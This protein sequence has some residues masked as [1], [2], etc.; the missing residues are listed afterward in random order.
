[1]TIEQT[2]EIPASHRLTLDLP[3]EIPVGRVIL[4]FTP[5]PP[6]PSAGSRIGFLRGQ[7]SVPPDF[8]TMGQAE[9]AA[10]FGENS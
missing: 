1:M 9:I 2:V 6:A 7:I 3:H 4:T 5:V 8:D 10:L